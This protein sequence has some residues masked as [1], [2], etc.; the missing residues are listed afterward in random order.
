MQLKQALRF[1][2]ISFLILTAS[3]CSSSTPTPA[4]AVATSTAVIEMATETPAPATDTPQPTETAA[5]TAETT[6]Q[7]TSATGTQPA[8]AAT[9]PAP[10]QS[11]A[12]ADRYQYVSQNLA[13]SLQVRPGTPLT[14]SWT[15]KN[16]GATGWSTTY[17]LKHFAGVES[18]VES[19][20]LGKNV[21]PGGEVT[22]TVKITAPS[23]EGKYNTWWKLQNA[24]GQNFGDVDFTFIVT[25]TP[26]AATPTP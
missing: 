13:D 8:A 1:G 14:I 3:A 23:V 26:G 9:Q 20:P 16:V 18:T 24:N 25:A 22:I 6:G 10:A 2:M 11:G 19:V 5:V 7:P 15:V 12:P 4:P 21:A 17:L